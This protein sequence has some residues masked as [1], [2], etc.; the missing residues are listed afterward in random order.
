[1]A[2]IYNLLDFD[3]DTEVTVNFTLKDGKEYSFPSKIIYKNNFV[4]IDVIK[5]NGNILNFKDT[6]IFV[7]I[8]I[9][10]FDER[11]V[12]FQKCFLE[13][14]KSKN[15]IGYA[16]HS[17][18]DGIEVNRRGAFRMYLGVNANIVVG[19]NSNTSEAIVKDISYSGIAITSYKKID[20]VGKKI[21]I[22]FDD[23]FLNY[24]F[25]LIATMVR[26]IEISEDKYVYGCSFLK[27]YPMLQKYISEKQINRNNYSYRTKKIVVN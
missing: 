20:F 18:I 17:L 1:M 3:I 11:P 5:F 24:H 12:L 4:F 16:V 14:V 2:K 23:K 7:S 9:S 15:F 19:E 27:E 13:T 26:E 25:D 21:R 10:N 6:K 22:T 8:L